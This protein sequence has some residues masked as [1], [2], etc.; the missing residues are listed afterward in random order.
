MIVVDAGPLVALADSDDKHHARTV[1]WLSR[2][3]QPLAVP[4]IV[5]AEACY[6]IEREVNARA[7]ARFVRELIGSP[8]FHVTPPTDNDLLRAADLV[9]QYADLRIGISDATVV[10]VAERLHATIIATIDT[11]HFR[12]V[13]PRHVAGFEIVPA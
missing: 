12:A 3:S 9:E 6:L 8:Q 4:T 10:A 2:T 7:E 13:R 5:L 11:R 1:A